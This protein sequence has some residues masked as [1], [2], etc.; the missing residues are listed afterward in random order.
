MH[1]V[2]EILRTWSGALL[3]CMAVID[4]GVGIKTMMSEQY[5]QYPVWDLPVRLFHW[6]NFFSVFSLIVVALIMMYKK[7]LGITGGRVDGFL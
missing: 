3:S 7:E 1:G 5:R 2:I 6:I 4:H